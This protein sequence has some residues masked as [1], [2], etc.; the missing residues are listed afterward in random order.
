MTALAAQ[1]LIRPSVLATGRGKLILALLCSIAFLDFVDA[2]ITNVAL[3]LIRDDLH[4]SVQG[5]QWVP[6]GYLLTYGGFMLLGGRLADLLGRRRIVAF[7]TALIGISSLAGGLAQNEGTL[8]AARLAQGLGAALML[9]A[10]LSI[11]TTTFTEP[12]DRHKALGVWGGVG[13]LASAAGVLL[14]GLLTDGPG[15]RWVFFVN[16]PAAALVFL[17]IFGLIEPDGPRRGTRAFDVI[18]AVL[19]TAGM[20][21][22]VFTL[23]K[24]PDEGWGS[25]ATVLG[26]VGSGV[27]LAAFVAKE[28]TGKDPLLPL[29]IFRVRGLAAADVTQLIAFAGFLAIFFFL[30]LYMQNV[31]GYSPIKTG[32]AYLPLCGAIGVSA[33][34]TGQLI[35][36][37]GTRPLIAGGALITSAGVYELARVPVN[38]SYVSDLLPGL[39]IVAFGI[40]AVFVATVT[41][42][43]DGVPAEK[44]GIAAALLNASQQLGGALGLAIF[45]AIATARTNHLLTQHDAVPHAL[46]AGFHRALL[47]GSVFLLAAAVIA[48]RSPNTRGQSSAPAEPRTLEGAQR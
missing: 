14:G 36:R 37:I 42:A 27:L 40:G 18:G 7:G 22:L 41:A 45:S 12:A 26:L 5:L 25:T 47:A 4:L 6:S 1:R 31:L 43:N 33:G 35:G 46:T 20:L 10:A 39:L 29:D 19:A 11:L 13:G 28:A 16:P 17:A 44:A 2:S 38:G 23:V 32:A 3:P 21:L 34:I 15:W 8:V 24:A 30:T 9:P 48:I